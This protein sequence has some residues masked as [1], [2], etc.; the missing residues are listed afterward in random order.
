MFAFTSMGAD[1]DRHI[2]DRGGP[3]VF[4]MSGQSYHRIGSLLPNRGADP[5]F[6]ELYIHVYP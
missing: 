3:H 5:K 4:K 1:I 6:V 2:N